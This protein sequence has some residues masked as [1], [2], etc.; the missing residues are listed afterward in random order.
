MPLFPSIGEIDVV[1]LQDSDLPQLSR[2]CSACTAFF[3][4]VEGQPGSEATAAEILADLSPELAR[5]TKHVFGFMKRNE[6]IGVAELLQG[7]PSPSE[8]FIGL[9]LLHPSHR[10]AGLGTRLCNALMAWIG[11]EGGTA[12]RLLVQHQNH[13]ARGFWERQ[14][15]SVERETISRVGHLESPASVFLRAIREAA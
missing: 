14:R 11:R 13:R 2:L 5:G 8:W 1:R 3:E 10:G 4:L 12:V 9:L 15:F 6:L 7:Y